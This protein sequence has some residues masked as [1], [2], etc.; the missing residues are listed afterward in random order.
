MPMNTPVLPSKRT[1]RLVAVGAEGD[2]GHIAQAN[3]GAVDL[4]DDEIAE[5][6]KECRLVVEVSVT[7]T[8]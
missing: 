3:V 7:C 4:L 8:I 6:L 2:L 5:L 1:L